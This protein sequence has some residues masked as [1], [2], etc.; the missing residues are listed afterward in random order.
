MAGNYDIKDIGGGT[1]ATR[2]GASKKVDDF[3]K[4]DPDAFARSLRPGEKPHQKEEPDDSQSYARGGPVLP[5]S[6][7]VSHTNLFR[8]K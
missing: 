4:S 2:K 3:F 1:L 6:G 7:S 5:R 8:R